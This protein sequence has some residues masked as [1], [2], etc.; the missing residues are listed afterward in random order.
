MG[1]RAEEILSQHQKSAAADASASSGGGG[2]SSGG[3]TAA[4]V[5]PVRTSA[6]G[7]S[8]HKLGT[9]HGR[10]ARAAQQHEHLQRLAEQLR[11]ATLSRDHSLGELE[12]TVMQRERTLARIAG[13]QHE[14]A[15]APGMPIPSLMGAASRSQATVGFGAMASAA[16]VGA[17]PE[18][19]GDREA[20][21]DVSLDD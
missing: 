6:K 8:V 4:P 15:E 19:G 1:A 17:S 13:L 16:R 9:S 2:D 7:G 11:E 12:R 21:F 5:A 18:D 20:Y 14:T 3:A 10:S